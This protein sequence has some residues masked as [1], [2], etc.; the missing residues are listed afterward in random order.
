MKKNLLKRP[1]QGHFCISVVLLWELKQLAEIQ[2]YL[3]SCVEK[4]VLCSDWLVL[5]MRSG[6]Q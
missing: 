5:G 1:Q 4:L 6:S 3:N 2:L